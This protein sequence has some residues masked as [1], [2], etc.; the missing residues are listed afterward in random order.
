MS[1][2]LDGPDDAAIETAIVNDVAEWMARFFPGDLPMGR[3]TMAD[4]REIVQLVL[5]HPKLKAADRGLAALRKKAKAYDD[6]LFGELARDEHGFPITADDW[7]AFKEQHRQQGARLADADARETQLI[8][9]VREW[10]YAFENDTSG[11]L[12]EEAAARTQ[13][14]IGSTIALQEWPKECPKCHRT[15]GNNWSHCDGGCPMWAALA[16]GATPPTENG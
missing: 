6:F 1:V 15:S 3:L 11:G 7:E 16:A 5:G 2:T 9:L 12:S 8:S 13:A 14:L 10:L 4:V